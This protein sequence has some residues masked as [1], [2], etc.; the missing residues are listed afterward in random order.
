MQFQITALVKHCEET[1]DRLRTNKKLSDSGK[2]VELTNIGPR[3]Q[4][5]GSFPCEP[6]LDVQKLQGF[7]L[8]GDHSDVDIFI[9]GHGLVARGHKLI[10]SIWSTPFAKVGLD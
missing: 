3:I 1:I 8:N 5:Y 4:Y 2:E 7:F 10:L 6:P 9:D